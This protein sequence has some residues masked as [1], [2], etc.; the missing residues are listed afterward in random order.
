M[1]TPSAPL[2]SSSPSP[3]AADAVAGVADPAL[4]TVIADHWEY[5][6]RW[7]PTWATTLGDHRYDDRL[8]PRDA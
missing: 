8:A 2:S 4:R 6:M 3:L 1:T 7:A 5:W